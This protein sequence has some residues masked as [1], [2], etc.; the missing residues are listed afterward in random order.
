MKVIKSKKKKHTE[1]LRH[2]SSALRRV[3][4]HCFAGIGPS[5]GGRGRNERG[6]TAVEPLVMVA[7]TDACRSLHVVKKIST[8]KK[9]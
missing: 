8:V 4:V 7:V 2:P 9:K 6:G 3:R 1:P 5:V